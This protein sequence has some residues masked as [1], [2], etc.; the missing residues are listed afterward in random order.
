M[1]CYKP[2]RAW[3]CANGDVVFAEL[4]RFD[5]TR[6]LDLPCGQCVGCRLERSRQWA[7]RCLHEAK[8]HDRNCFVTLTYNNDN[9]PADR[10]LNYR[11]FQLFMK[12]LRFH[13]RGVPIRFYMCGEYG[14][15]FGRPHFHACLFGLDFPDKTRIS[16][17]EFPLVSQ[18]R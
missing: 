13:F 12:R 10:S 17:G 1:A 9:V 15:D 4:G 2:L 8:M 11:D 5:I 18:S 7:M 14:E 16:G 6:Q 3:Q